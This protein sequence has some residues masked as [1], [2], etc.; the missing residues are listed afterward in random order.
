VST[1]GDAIVVGAHYEDSNATGVNG[2]QNNNGAENSGAAY[3]FVSVGN[4]TTWTQQPYLKAS[5]TGAADY[6]GT[7]VSISGDT[8]VVGA[9]GEDSNA[10]GVN[11]DQNNNDASLSGAAYVFVRDGN[12]YQSNNDA[13]DSGAVYVLVRVGIVWTQ[14][15]YLKAS[16][17]V[18]SSSFGY[19]V[20]ISED[21][22][23]VGTYQEDSNATGVNGDQNNNDA[24][25]SGAAYVFVRDWSTWTQQAYLKASNTDA[26]DYFGYS[27][28]ISGDTIV[29]GAYQEDSNATGVNGD[30]DNN[31]NTSNSGAAYVFVRVGTIWTQQAYLKASNTGAGDYFGI[32]VSVSGDTIVVGADVEDSNA[33]EVNGDQDNDGATNSGAAYVFVRDKTT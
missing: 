31:N 16:N 11:G 8:I 32:A 1:S 13:L 17:T 29:V 2:D 22:I 21:T 20:S 33:T 26:G 19:S 30:Q 7:S 18:F 12:G 4:G 27:V 14:Q 24:S 9:Y 23:V 10:T 25:S 28:S 15:A 5:N 6:F 3:V